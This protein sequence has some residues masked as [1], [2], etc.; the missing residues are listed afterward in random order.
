MFAV[1]GKEGSF[2]MHS[3]RFDHCAAQLAD[4]SFR[5]FGVHNWPISQRPSL[6]T[7]QKVNVEFPMSYLGFMK[8]GRGRVIADRLP[9]PDRVHADAD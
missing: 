3:Y 1:G 2:V 7:A 5:P 6:L 4:V 8:L 9:E